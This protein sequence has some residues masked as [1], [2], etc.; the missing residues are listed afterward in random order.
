MTFWRMAVPSLALLVVLFAASTIDPPRF[1]RNTDSLAKKAWRALYKYELNRE[2]HE[3]QTAGYYE[4]LLNEGS[5]VS[6]MN[7]LVTGD[8]MFRWADWDEPGTGRRQRADFRYWDWHPNVNV[9]RENPPFAL[10]TN[11]HGM[12]DREHTL[13]KPPNTFRVALLGD[14]ITRGHG[15][16]VGGNYEALLE[17]RLNEEQAARGGPVVELLN[18]GV[19][20]Y[21]ITQLVDAALEWAAPFKPDAY[22]VTFSEV[23]VF[24]RWSHHIIALVQNGVDLKYDYLRRLVREA[25]LGRTDPVGTA[26][27][28][29]A[30]YRLPTLR[31]AV[32]EIGAQAQRDGARLLV[33]LLPDATDLE[34]LEEE[35]I[36]VR[37]MLVEE[38]VPYIDLLDVFADFEDPRDFLVAEDDLHPNEAGHRVLFERLHAQL[39]ADPALRSHFAGGTDA[40]DGPGAW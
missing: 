22:V 40:A 14:S 9:S 35:F 13:Y 15:A 12:A 1:R 29:L 30:R 28:K 32:R 24:A 20:G 37:D 23:T 4:G 10:S 18:F 17:Q 39:A 5:R 36:G 16:P 6:A 26:D 27:A 25:R 8:Q 2:A 19:N 11:S 3:Q 33:L 21:R 38:G 31:W 34:I 7:R